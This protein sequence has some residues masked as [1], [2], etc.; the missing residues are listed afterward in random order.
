MD[1]KLIKEANQTAQETITVDLSQ[2]EKEIQIL[3]ARRVREMQDFR[4]TLKVEK[5]WKEADLE[6]EPS[7]LEGEKSGR[8]R[9]ETDDELGYRG[10]MVPIEGT[11][12]EWRSKNS[13]PTLLAK[14]QTALSIVIDQIPEVEF[15]ALLKRYKKTNNLA[16]ALWKRNWNISEAKD[17]YKLFVFNMVKYGWGAGRTYPK[18]IQ[19]EKDI[20]VSKDAENPANDQYEKTTNVWFDDICK[21]NLNPFRTWIDEQTK[22]YLDYS[23][24]DWYF[25]LDY[26]YDAAKAEFGH[27]PNFEELIKENVNLKMSY[28]EEGQAEKDDEQKVRQDIVTIGFYENRLK[29]LYT[30]YIPKIKG[31]LHYCPLPNDDGML[32]LWHAPWVLRSAENPYGVSMWE[33]IRQKK[34]LYDKMQNMT[35]DQLVLSIMKMF[36][37]TGTSNLL[38]DGKIKIKPGAGHQITNGKIDFL[39][40]PGPGAD[41]WKGLDWVKKGMEDD[42][43]ITPTLQGES[44][45]QTL[46]QDLISKESSLKRL[47]LPVENIASAMEQDAYITLSWMAQ[48]YSTPQV[49]EFANLGDIQAYNQENE[50]QHNQIFGQPNPLDGSPMGPFKATYGPQL[51]LGLEQQGQNFIESRSENFFQVGKDIKSDQLYWRGMIKVVPKSIVSSSL[52]LEKQQKMQ[53]FNIIAPLLAQ[54]PQLFAKPVSE[55]AESLELDPKDWLP[56]TWIQFLEQE[57]QGLFVPAADPMAAMAGGAPGMGKGVQGNQ[58]TMQGGAGTTPGTQSPTVVPGNQMPAAVST[59]VNTAPPN[60]LAARQ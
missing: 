19:Y 31:V 11:E 21:E 44:Q 47:K 5:R 33:I 36:F 56:D 53:Y 6:Y 58:T 7:E 14:I 28:E 8:M 52:E 16:K 55:L 43:G 46:G 50:V 45:G 32:S 37:Y 13:D 41:A 2:K 40:I 25:E 29:D 4:K 38:G 1:E 17:V 9:V 22:P 24:N 57:G 30:L 26:S 48:T 20:L 59:G 42:S 54:P 51:N 10:R 34:S 12:D 3:V 15:V 39:E 60:Y 35:M 23:T 49:M 27:Y 18:K